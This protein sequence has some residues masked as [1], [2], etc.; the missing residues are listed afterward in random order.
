MHRRAK[1][2]Y[3]LPI[4]LGDENSLIRQYFCLI[5]ISAIM[6]QLCTKERIGAAAVSAVSL[7]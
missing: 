2:H 7:A 1:L 5:Q 6:G 3:T 4:P